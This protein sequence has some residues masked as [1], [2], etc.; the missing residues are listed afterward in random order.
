MTIG[1]LVLFGKKKTLQISFTNK[2]GK[3]VRFN[4][5]EA[6]LS[7]TLKTLKTNS[8]EQLSGMEVELEEVAGQA[9]KIR[10]VGEAW[11]APTSQRPPANQNRDN[12]S[13]SQRDR[14][15]T[16]QHQPAQSDFHNPYNFVPA[17]PRDKAIAK[18]SELGDRHPSGHGVYHQALWSGQIAIT[19]T[20]QTP[21]LLP[22]AAQLKEIKDGEQKGHKTFKTRVGADGLPLLPATSIK[23]MLRSAYEIIT[24]SRLTIFEKHGDRLAYRMPPKMSLIPAQ[25]KRLD[26]DVLI[27][28]LMESVRLERYKIGTNLPTDKGESRTAKKYQSNG[29]LPKHGKP[30]WVQIEEDTVIK[31]DPRKI[32]ESKPGWIKGWV[33]LTGANI[34]NKRFERVFIETEDDKILKFK[35]QEKARIIQLWEDLIKDYKEIHEKDLKQRRERG[36]D[37]AAYLGDDPG[38]TGWS[39]HIYENDAENLKRGIL[40]YVEMDSNRRITALLPVTISRHLHNTA[41]TQLLDKTLY[42]PETIEDLS[43][44]DRVFGWVRR[45]GSKRDDFKTAYKGNLRI[46]AVKCQAKHAEAAIKSFAGDGLPLAI[47]GAPKPAQARFYIAQDQQGTPLPQRSEKAKSYQS[48]QGLRGRKVYPH[49]QGLPENHWHDPMSDRTQQAQNGHFQEYRRPKKGGQEQRD[50]QNRSIMGWVKEGV[51]FTAR[52]DITNL[53][54]VELG[55][56]L[57]LLDLPEKHVHRLGGGKPLGFGSVRST[58][59][60]EQTDLRNGSDWQAFYKTLDDSQNAGQT[61]KPK[62]AI[63]LFKQEVEKIYSEPFQ[64]V[65]FIQAFLQAARG[66]EDQKPVHY[67]RVRRQGQNGNPPPHPDGESF[68][69]FTENER[70]G[71][72]GGDQISLPPLTNETGLPYLNERTGR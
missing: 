42:P 44:V 11:Q 60:W 69:W 17:L 54:S 64:Q 1:K 49:H 48:G 72:N 52:I 35:E 19:L 47:L 3:D 6:E 25:V 39:R 45:A 7:A 4:V 21:L 46:S 68:K 30:V 27:I 8:P 28:R 58:I 10:P 36:D 15:P 66:F 26:D 43:P 13:Q 53:S 41:P 55:A 38:K 65:S 71:N 70:T 40:C 63:A 67:P 31:V 23:G 20:T 9:T 12:R 61:S 37:P 24:N 16:Q 18:E 33:C 5:K 22:D 51:S 29:E 59:D 57:Y 62:D 32:E 50:D 56:L 14:Q 34:K 2:K